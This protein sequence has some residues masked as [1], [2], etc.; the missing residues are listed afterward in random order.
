MITLV[1]KKMCELFG[2]QK[3]YV[4][5]LVT[6]IV[7]MDT[8][9]FQKKLKESLFV[10]EDKRNCLHS[11]EQEEIANGLDRLNNLIKRSETAREEAMD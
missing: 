10:M 4:T 3:N 6:S 11:D 7:N 2:K 5:L 8:E 9:I 1:K